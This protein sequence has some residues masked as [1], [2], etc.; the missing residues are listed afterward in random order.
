MSTLDRTRAALEQGIAERLHLGAQL[1]A[2]LDGRRYELAVGDARPGVPMRPDTV[3]HWLS[4]GKPLAVVAIAQ[5]WERGLLELDDPVAK[6][7]PAFGN[8]GKEAVTIRHILT[9]TGGFRGW[10]TNWD[11]P[12]G[13]VLSD[14]MNLP[15]ET[16]WSPGQKAGYHPASSW[17]VLGELVRVLDGRPYDA[18]VRAMI[19]DPLH[20]ADAW[21]G[22]PPDEY[23]RY[24]GGGRLSFN[25]DTEQQLDPDERPPTPEEAARPSPGGGLRATAGDLVAFY[26]MLLARGEAPGGQRVL[27]PQTVEAIV[28]RHR[29]GLPDRTFGRAMDFGLG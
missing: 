17:F 4:S 12:L 21:V 5:L 11:R 23:A 1:C 25:Y 20:M 6:H 22:L 19:A 29:V 14:V 9:H 8:R 28:A 18:Y 10:G 7:L 27:L 13:Q 3:N 15:L 26:E 16:G 2:S 24:D